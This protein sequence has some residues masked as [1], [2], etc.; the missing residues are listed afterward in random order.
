MQQG[1]FAV[2][3]FLAAVCSAAGPDSHHVLVLDAGARRGAD[4]HRLVL[5]EVES[6]KELA[7][8]E[9]DTATNVAVSGDGTAVAALTFRNDL[10]GRETRLN[11][12]RANDLSLIETGTLAETSILPGRLMAGYGANIHFSPDSKEIVYCGL[13]PREPGRL[14][15]VDLATTAIV[16]LKQDLD[17]GHTYRPVVAATI[18]PCRGIRFVSVA[19]WPKVVVLNETNTELLVIDLDRGDVLNNLPIAEPAPVSFMP[20]RLRGICLSDNGRNA[21]FLPR[22]PGLLKKINLSGDPQVTLARGAQDSSVRHDVAAVSERAGRIFMLDDR[23][24]P[25]GLYAPTRWVKVFSTADLGFQQEIEVPLADCHWLAASRDGKYLYAT[26]PLNG[27]PFDELSIT[28]SRLAVI[29]ASTGREV[30]ILEAGQ[31][32]ALV[33]PIAE[34]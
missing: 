27:P 22:K 25:A 15:N 29:D 8:V 24:N 32:P 3:C 5:V 14:A 4:K 10:A 19:D 23:R 13:A 1:V 18:S 31:R 16:R 11:F 17:R 6:G 12:Y 20:M 7:N 21:Y 2:F 9:L 28:Q 33:F 30:K 26:G 34:R